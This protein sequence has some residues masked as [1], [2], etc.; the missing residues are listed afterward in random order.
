M[1]QS[2]RPSR[3]K[4]RTLKN[5]EY[6]KMENAL[7]KWFLRQRELNFPATGEMC[8]EGIFVSMYIFCIYIST[9]DG[10]N[11]SII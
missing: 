5:A 4:Q 2:V 8:L 1:N 9:F 7:N 10:V 11:I 6:P 3:I